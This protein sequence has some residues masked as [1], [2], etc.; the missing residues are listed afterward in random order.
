MSGVRTKIGGRSKGTPNKKTQALMDKAEELGVNP[1]E[2]VLLYAKR[3]WAA[4]GFESAT[5]TRCAKGGETF[6]EDR[7]TAK[8]QLDAA[9]EACQYLY[10]K[11]K[12]IEHS[13]DEQSPLEM[14]VALSLEDRKEL[15]KIARNTKGK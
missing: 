9:S 14:R 7:I 3:D 8:M 15:V 12:A 2:V 5:V 4:L 1:F 13:T 11:R 10:P 6:E